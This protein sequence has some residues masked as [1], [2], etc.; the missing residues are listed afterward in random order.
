MLIDQAT[1]SARL[2]SPAVAADLARYIRTH[3]LTTLLSARSKP[4]RAERS[5]AGPGPVNTDDHNRLEYGSPI[6]YFVAADVE[7]PDERR[8]PTLGRGLELERYRLDHPQTLA[9]A[10]DL[11]DSLSWVH[12]PSD[13][14][15]RAAAERWLELAPDSVDATTAVARAALHPGQHLHRRGAAG[16][17]R[18]PR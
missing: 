13:G 15:V 11:Y 1:L 12:P 18:R 2:A 4:T 7:V 10:A 9:E 3:E 6:A 5:F 8:P 17:A 16:A 14:L